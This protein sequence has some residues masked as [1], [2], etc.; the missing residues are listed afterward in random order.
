MRPLS[1]R[2]AAILDQLTAGVCDDY[3]H[4]RIDNAPGA[5]MAAVVEKIGPARYSVA[6]YFVQ[7]GDLVADPDLEFVKQDGAWFPAAITQ[8]LGYSCPIT[9][10][11]QGRIVSCRPHAYADLRSFAGMLLTNIK[12]QQGDLSREP[13]G[14]EGGETVGA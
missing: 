5:F 3:P 10:D 8:V 12:H 13:A 9:T 4:R 6:H 14:E 1:K 11:E 2:H 7:N